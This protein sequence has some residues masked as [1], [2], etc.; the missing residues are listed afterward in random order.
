MSKKLSDISE[1]TT[2]YWDYDLYLSSFEA[3][4]NF[5]G[6]RDNRKRC[7]MC[8]KPIN[9]GE[10]YTEYDDGYARIPLHLACD[11]GPKVY[12]A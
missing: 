2:E 4:L 12:I 7:G 3:L 10:R 9:P 8:G 11:Y 5:I 6:P 1:A